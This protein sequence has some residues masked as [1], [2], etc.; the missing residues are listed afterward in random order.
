MKD[1]KGMY[2]DCHP[3]DQPSGSYRYAKN[4]IVNREIGMIQ[5]EIGDYP[6]SLVE[7]TIAEIY[8]D[9]EIFLIFHYE[10]I[11]GQY[12]SHISTFDGT[13]HTILISDPSFLFE[14]AETVENYYISIKAQINNKGELIT[15]FTDGIQRPRFV[16]LTATQSDEFKEQTYLFPKTQPAQFELMSVSSG[17]RIP[18]G[19]YYIFMAYMTDD[20]FVTNYSTW[21]KEIMLFNENDSSNENS[22]KTLRFRFNSLDTSFGKIKV[23]IAGFFNNTYRAFEIGE[24]AIDSSQSNVISLSNT[25]ILEE[26]DPRE[27]T[28]DNPV[29]TAIETL[30][31]LN[32]YLYAGN[33][34]SPDKDIEGLQNGVINQMEVTWGIDSDG[35]LMDTPVIADSNKDCKKIYE[36]KGFMPDE[37][38][39]LYAAPVTDDGYELPAMHIPGQDFLGTVRLD[40]ATHFKGGNTTSASI[41]PL[42]SI[43]EDVKRAWG[44][45]SKAD[46]LKYFHILNTAKFG[47]S[48]GYWE[49]ENEYYPQDQQEWGLLAGQKVRHH[50]TP[51]LGI[52]DQGDILGFEK[53]TTDFSITKNSSGN[54]GKDGWKAYTL[55]DIED[56][57][58]KPYSA[59]IEDWDYVI[60]AK[61]D[62]SIYLQFSASAKLTG[63]NKPFW[64]GRSL[65]Y[66]SISV[67]KVDRYG[68]ESTLS[69]IRNERLGYAHYAS[70]EAHKVELRNGEKLRYRHA[71]YFQVADNFLGSS[72]GVLE[73]YDCSIA[74]STGIGITPKGKSIKLSINIPSSVVNTLATNFPEVTGFNFYYALRSNDNKTNFGYSPLVNPDKDY[75]VVNPTSI[76]T[77]SQKTKVYPFE[78]L[79]NQ[80]NL[81]VDFID[82][83]YLAN[84]PV[85]VSPDNT[86]DHVYDIYHKKSGQSSNN[87][88]ICGVVSSEYFPANNSATEPTNAFGEEAVLLTMS[89]D[90]ELN[91]FYENGADKHAMA[92]LKKIRR[93]VFFPYSSQNLVKCGSTAVPL[94]GSIRTT[95]TGDTFLNMYGIRITKQKLESAY[96]L[97]TYSDLNIA[98]REFGHQWFET[99]YPRTRG[100]WVGLL[101]DNAERVIK[102]VEKYAEDEYSRRF[103]NYMAYPFNRM[104][105]IKFEFPR[106]LNEDM[107][108]DFP[109]RIIS[110]DQQDPEN[111]RASWRSF[112]PNNYFELDKLRGDVVHLQ[113]Q[114]GRLI[115]HT[116]N[117]AYI[118]Q[119]NSQMD[120]VADGSVFLGKGGIFSTL[121]TP[122]CDNGLAQRG[123][124]FSLFG[125]YIYYSNR[126]FYMISGAHQQL[127][128]GVNRL[129]DDF[130]VNGRLAYVYHPDFK[131]IFISNGKQTISYDILGQH[132]NSIHEWVF[133]FGGNLQKEVY[134]TRG[135]QIYHYGKGDVL[136]FGGEKKEMLFDFV[137][138]SPGSGEQKTVKQN[139]QLIA[140]NL[141]WQTQVGNVQLETFDKL[142]LYC[143]KGC[144][145]YVTVDKAYIDM[146][147]RTGSRQRNGKWTLNSFWDYLKQD[148]P[149]V[150]SELEGLEIIEENLESDVHWSNLKRIKD[151]H[152]ICRF[153]WG[154]TQNLSDPLILLDYKLNAR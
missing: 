81:G 48:M 60:T 3:K 123:H 153:V 61:E 125:T 24:Y 51:S 52:L 87:G 111:N 124:Q 117:G 84:N 101:D 75:D 25:S 59:T 30:E 139:Y 141:T 20:R 54:I 80:A 72:Y 129:L 1:I 29:Y 85:K 120:T 144:S 131:M 10:L 71:Y 77:A 114:A 78:A 76:K 96:Y 94:S 133:A 142:A 127:A 23:A 50:V 97:P 92:S 73:S 57:D 47:G 107:I 63:V 106:N 28:I 19:T 45:E 109:N 137:T 26:I 37:V 34:K 98:A 8:N 134:L 62:I 108:G 67:Y 14:Q 58:D 121:P 11:E 68:H 33:L 132:W 138:N 102:E 49:N 100:S 16:N 135:S 113:E 21:S 91:D 69:N 6:L 43:P 12:T 32:G 46:G 82:I 38:Y 44:L 115:I 154:N 146:M 18:R 99:F 83:S 145:G 64:G 128:N 130:F 126:R 151:N 55:F 143:N 53:S 147:A 5:S 103:S 66:E 31:S 112:R 56:D 70:S 40:P 152:I 136:T 149:A 35:A 150:T 105:A 93:D 15:V 90:I 27:V 95:L 116:S 39:A 74:I 88:N 148:L 104:G 65:V 79:I 42:D 118:T 41:H 17:G 86:G 36:C 122:I 140:K 22:G 119:G 110:S 7:G 2:L 89:Q 4:V 9:N 13:T